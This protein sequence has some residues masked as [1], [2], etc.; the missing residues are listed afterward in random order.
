HP[1]GSGAVPVETQVRPERCRRG[2]ASVAPEVVCAVIARRSKIEYARDRL[3]VVADD[4]AVVVTHE[5][6]FPR[7]QNAV[8]A[9]IDPYPCI[10]TG[11][12]LIACDLV[13]ERS[14]VRRFFEPNPADLLILE[15]VVR[16]HIMAANSVID[17]RHSGLAPLE[18]VPVHEDG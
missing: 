7:T 11:G 9:P 13:D 8:R 10:A 17:D 2:R 5:C 15:Y 4:D 3:A 14:Y 16:N 1:T 18:R 12:Y 6:I